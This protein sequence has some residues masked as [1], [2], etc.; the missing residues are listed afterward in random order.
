MVFLNPVL[1]TSRSM[2]SP[3]SV[4]TVSE[5]VTEPSSSPPKSA[6]STTAHS[7]RLA[8]I[9]IFSVRA[10]ESLSRPGFP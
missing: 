3:S 2:V 9:P 8:G 7:T 6:H 4:S 1:G 5:V 10:S